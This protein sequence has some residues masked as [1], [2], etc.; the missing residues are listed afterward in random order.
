MKLRK[1][2]IG[3]AAAAVA[4]A[5]T[6]CGAPGSATSGGSTSTSAAGAGPY[7]LAVAESPTFEAGTTMAK[8]AEAGTMKIGTKFDQPLF[9]LRGL[10]GKPVGFD[11][12][13]GSLVASKLGIPFDK[14]EWTETVSANREPFLQS[15]QVDAVI[16]TYTI[17][18]KRKQVVD[19]A[20]P[21]FVAGQSILVL[22][23]NTEITKPEDLAGKAVCSVEG[24]TPASNI[25]EKYG[26]VLQPT[27]VYSKCLDP[28]KNG[29]VVAMTTDNVILSG[30][31]DQNPGVFKLV[32]DTFTQEPYG[33]G[34]TKDDTAMRTFVNE[35]LQAA[36]D[37]GTWA[38]L[39]EQTAGTVIPVPTPPT[40]DQY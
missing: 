30:F 9:G 24:S 8:L 36:Y 20:G 14:I 12:A 16:A 5:L 21:Y 19:F 39:F 2:L 11:A 6:A 18:D 4:V 23:G 1:I 26:A 13:I 7:D 25:V 31:V 37:D 40:I 28:L 38:R 34:L 32:G 27:D 3:T 22:E 35:T 10:D 29:Q 15:G 17:N 33:I